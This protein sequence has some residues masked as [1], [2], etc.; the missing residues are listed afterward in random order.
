[1]R[2]PIAI[3]IGTVR[4]T[5]DAKR[6]LTVQDGETKRSFLAENASLRRFLR[7]YAVFK[8]PPPRMTLKNSEANRIRDE[9]IEV[10]SFFLES[11]RGTG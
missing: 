8:I 11:S 4:A 7:C 3:Q 9:H 1:M 6:A 2:L 10:W 5:F